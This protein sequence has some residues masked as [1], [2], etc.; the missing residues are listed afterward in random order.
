MSDITRALNWSLM[1]SSETN[2]DAGTKEIDLIGLI[3]DNAGVLSCAQN[4][5]YQT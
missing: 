1:R 3:E 5:I 4:F 2:G